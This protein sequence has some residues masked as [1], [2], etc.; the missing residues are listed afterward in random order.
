[1]PCLYAH[2]TRPHGIG[3]DTGHNPV[4]AGSVAHQLVSVVMD[5][6]ARRV[7]EGDHGVADFI[8][9]IVPGYGVIH[10][11]CPGWQVLMDYQIAIRPCLPDVY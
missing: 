3:Y 6:P 2:L 7:I 10:Q 8:M 4:R 1:M 11:H 9:L 5:A